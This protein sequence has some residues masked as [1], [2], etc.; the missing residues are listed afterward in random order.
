M[1]LNTAKTVILPFRPWTSTTQLL[2]Q[3]L[4]QLGVEVLE[5]EGR[6]KLLGIYYGPTL[7]N[8]D[9]L[10]HLIV[11]MQTRCSL[12]SYRARTLRGQVVI[13]QQIILPVLWFSASV[14]HVPQ[15]GF[16]HQVDSVIARFICRSK[17]NIALSKQWWFLPPDKGG[18]GLTPISTMIQS[19]QLNM[20]C[21]VILTTRSSLNNAVPSWVD[22][23]IQIF[24]SAIYPWG[25][26]FDILYAPIS[27][28]PDFVNA[29]KSPRW[30]KLGPYWHYVFYTWNVHFR[31][32]I[33]RMQCKFDKLTTPFLDNVDINYA[34]RGRTLAG[35]AKPLQLV[36][37]LSTQRIF[38]PI[39]LFQVCPAPITTDALS[40]FLRHIEPCT[41]SNTRSCTNFL[42]RL[43][44]LLQGINEPLI[45]PMQTV[46]YYCAFHA[47]IFNTYEIAELSVARIR[48][49]LIQQEVPQLP[50]IR[51]GVELPPPDLMWKRD[52]KMNKHLLPVYADLLYRLQHNA[53]FLGYRLQHLPTADTK[54]HFGCATLETAAHLFWYCGLA[55]QLWTDWLP[56]L[57][58]FFSSSLSW[59]SLLFFK[60][61]ATAT[62]LS[63]FGYNIYLILHIVRAVIFR[64]LWM[65]RNDVRFHSTQPNSIAVQATVNSVVRL[66]IDRYILDLQQKQ[67]SH[68]GLLLRKLRLL[69]ELLPIPRLPPE[70]DR[71][72]T[73]PLSHDD[74]LHQELGNSV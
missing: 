55:T 52:M 57:Q 56:V 38:R 33:V 53:L 6:T 35:T 39:D 51:L 32:K 70:E 43:R 34:Y 30:L 16:Q 62:A 36:S 29:S 13:L 59:E 40:K 72:Q 27:T 2:K 11:D 26:N 48:K 74:I 49:I 69:L 71:F 18:L 41:A 28:S 4:Q 50:L 68:S 23:I 9:R 12:W 66:H 20:L 8:A 73:E 15:T 44:V 24:D 1:R 61:E 47:W 19:L 42:L 7:N 58:Q 22:P 46:R 17:S 25:I 14:C 65:H 67:L 45:G 21:K 31:K 10:Q 3:D 64:S 60:V 37:T 5:N 63:R 54:C